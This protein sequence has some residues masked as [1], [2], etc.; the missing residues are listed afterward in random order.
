M[1]IQEHK[2]FSDV[3]SFKVEAKSTMA[4]TSPALKNSISIEHVFDLNDPESRREHYA[5]C[6][7]W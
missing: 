5:Q 1:L 4:F 7:R 2:I 3:G 6:Y